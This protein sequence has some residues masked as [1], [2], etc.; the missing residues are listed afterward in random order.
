MVIRSGD[1]SRF[2]PTTAAI[3]SA[4]AVG[5]PRLVFGHI[6]R[7]AHGVAAGGEY[8]VLPAFDASAVG[9]RCLAGVCEPVH[10]GAGSCDAIAAPA[11][12]AFPT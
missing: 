11:P 9:L 3:A 6:H 2:L 4:M 12:S 1:Q 10:F 5:V 7:F 8:W